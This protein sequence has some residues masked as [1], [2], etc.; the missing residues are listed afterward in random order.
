[1]KNVKLT[2][3]RPIKESSAEYDKLED[4]IKRAFIKYLYGP[5]LKALNTSPNKILNSKYP[6]SELATAIES[7]QLEFSDGVFK[8]KLTAT[9]SRQLKAA[10]AK[11]N[12]TKRHYEIGFFKLPPDVR[13]AIKASE[14]MFHAKLDQVDKMLL[15]KNLPEEITRNVKSKDLFSTN[16]FKVDRELTASLKNLSVIPN[17]TKDDREKIA[18]EWQDNMDLFIKGFAE[19]E[20]KELRERV[21][22]SAF[23]GNRKESLTQMIKESYGVTERKAKFLARQETMLMMTKLKEVRYTK[24][25]INHY[26]WKNVVGSPNHPVRPSHKILDS[27]IFTWNDPPITTAPGEPVR[28]NNPGQD[29]NCRCLAIPVFMR[30]E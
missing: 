11:W 15:E 23:Q 16:I 19:K 8:G 27:K 2:E 5:L 6:I 22:V 9:L 1:M 26:R 21:A 3:L 24:A 20:I 7:G 18:A 30:Q 13:E 4:R 10:G 12:K 28:R 25:G 29:F 14:A 17:L